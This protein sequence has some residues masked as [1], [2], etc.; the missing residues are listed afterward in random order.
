MTPLRNKGYVVRTMDGYI[1]QLSIEGVVIDIN[2]TFWSDKKPN[3]IWVQRI[4]EKIFEPK[5]MT[6]IDYI[7]KPI[8]NCYANKT[9]NDTMNYRGEFMFVGFKY[10]LMAFWEDKKDHQLNFEVKRCERQPILE[11]LNQLNKENRI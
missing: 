4:K 8:F 5:T 1:G 7:P 9:K 11:R 6:F 10:E 2:C 3:Y